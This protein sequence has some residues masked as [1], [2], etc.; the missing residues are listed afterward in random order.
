MTNQVGLSYNDVRKANFIG[1]KYSD[2][3]KLTTDL[4]VSDLALY[5][6]VSVP[7]GGGQIPDTGDDSVSAG[8]LMGIIMMSFGSCVLLHINI[9][10]QTRK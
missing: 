7:S 10:G 2:T 5:K 8:I 9:K 3:N 6:E 1:F 4:Y